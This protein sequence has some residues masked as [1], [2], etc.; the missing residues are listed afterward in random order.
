MGGARTA[1]QDFL[2]SSGRRSGRPGQALLLVRIIHNV[3]FIVEDH[4]RALD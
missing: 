1:L 2:C 3:A 4:R